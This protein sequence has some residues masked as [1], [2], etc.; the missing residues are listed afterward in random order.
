MTSLILNWPILKSLSYWN[1]EKFMRQVQMQVKSTSVTKMHWMYLK[2]VTQ[3]SEQVIG[4][5]VMD[6]RDRPGI[7]CCIAK[8]EQISRN[9]SLSF[10]RK[11]QSIRTFLYRK[12]NP[13]ETFGK[14]IFLDPYFSV[15]TLSNSSISPSSWKVIGTKSYFTFLND[16]LL[17]YLAKFLAHFLVHLNFLSNGIKLESQLQVS[18][19]NFSGF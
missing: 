10:I 3:S 11:L 19:L 13:I 2:S 1:R 6:Q 12:L 9:T 4:V 16:S 14:E 5:S 18:Q 17:E 8:S 15:F 7:P